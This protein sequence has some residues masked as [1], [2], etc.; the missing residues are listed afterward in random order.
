[1]S[2]GR[3][4]VGAT[5]VLAVGGAVVAA[6]GFG[7]GAAP[8]E[9]PQ[10]APSATAK[11]TRQTLVDTREENGSLGYGDKT[12]VSVRLQGTLTS[13]PTIGSVVQRGQT[14][15]QVDN[16]PVVLLYGSLPAYRT[17]GVDMEGADVKQFEENLAALGYK[18]FTVDNKFSSATTTAVKKWQK[19]LGLTETGVVDL[20]RVHYAPG[21]VRVD[22][23]KAN[24]GDEVRPGGELLEYTGSA[25]VV[26]VD[27]D[28]ADQ[29][30]AAKG[31]AVAVGLPGGKSVQGKVTSTATVV[32]EGS[33]PD[34][35]PSTRL[36]VTVTPTT[37]RPSQA[38]TRR[39]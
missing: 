7:S 18:G 8:E 29:T 11:V 28:L 9:S 12:A 38:S 10:P 14:L 24:V 36:R 21:A 3:I 17:L 19:A 25:R 27:L 31:A 32:D 6:T 22:K 1:M 13:V 20:G 37:R 34:A 5:V 33:G 2:R 35:E 23:A 30:I 15:C 39:R 26:T 16:T 4:A